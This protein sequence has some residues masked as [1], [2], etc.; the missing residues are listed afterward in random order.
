MVCMVMVAVIEF[1]LDIHFVLSFLYY[2]IA[3]KHFFFLTIKS[4]YLVENHWVWAGTFWFYQDNH[5][6]VDAYNLLP[7]LPPKLFVYHRLD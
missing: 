6:L 3:L 2:C 5:R 4:S 7:R 1:I